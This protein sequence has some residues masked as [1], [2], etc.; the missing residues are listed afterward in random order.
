MKTIYEC[1]KSSK[2]VVSVTIVFFLI[3]IANIIYIVY[4]TS[5]GVPTM[6]AVALIG[7]L[8]F[9]MLSVFVFIP[10]Y[11]ITTDE[12]ISIR[13][14]GYMR[15]I[16]YANIEKIVRIDELQLHKNIRVMGSGGVFG[17]IG[18]FWARNIGLYIAYVTDPKKVFMIY[19]KHGKPIAISVDEPEEFIPY[20]LKG[21][22]NE[23]AE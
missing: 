22:D 9:V 14:L 5:K 1:S 6:Y 11:I 16:P 20:Y 8:M 4:L 18:W 3:I 2:T 12:G 23:S 13:T 10:L 17:F 21:G 19:R 7:L 15:H